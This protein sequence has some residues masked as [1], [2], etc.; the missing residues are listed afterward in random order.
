MT[1]LLIL[2][3]SGFVGSNLVSYFA[4]RFR[5][6]TYTYCSSAT[7]VIDS[8]CRGVRL[9]VRDRSAVESVIRSVSPEVVVHAAGVKDVRACERNPAWAHSVNGEGT[10]N[11][12]RACEEAG[13]WLV[14]L[15]TDLVFACDRGGY[16]EGEQPTP[17]SEY[18]RSKLAGEISAR[19]ETE[20]LTI[21]RS[22]GIYGRR[23]PLLAWAA[24]ELQGGR[25]ISAFTDVRNTPTY[26]G[27]LAEMLDA[28]IRL[29]PQGP[30]HMVG[31][32]RVS[33]YEFFCSFAQSFDLDAAKILPAE[34]GDRRTDLHLTADASLDGRNTAQLLGVAQDG[35]ARGMGR[36]AAE[37]G[38]R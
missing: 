36:L 37:G 22:G 10:G 7:P 29:R 34:A 19:A 32:D 11:V 12:A 27:N 31:G 15:S 33:R 38:W 4:S 26:C 2:G 30:L 9:D 20:R 18:G 28:A 16:A 3:G 5:D 8:R 6:V 24:D 13:A 35:V 17:S 25:T 1:S 14:F 21:C 23:S